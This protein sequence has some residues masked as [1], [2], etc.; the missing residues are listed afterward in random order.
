MEAAETA[1]RHIAMGQFLMLGLVLVFDK[2]GRRG[3]RLAA[4]AAFAL[5]CYLYD[6]GLGST[7]TM[8][9]HVIVVGGLLGTPLIW[10]FI[11]TIFQDE[12]EAKWW[13]WGLAAL[14]PARYILRVALDLPVDGQAAETMLAA[15]RLIQM[16]MLL[17]GLFVALANRNNDLV[18][19]RRNKRLF[20]ALGGGGYILLRVSI[21]LAGLNDWFDRTFPLL[22]AGVALILATIICVGLLRMRSDELFAPARAGAP[23]EPPPGLSP[24]TAGSDTAQWGQRLLK[25]MEAGA[26]RTQGLTV[27]SLAE[28]INLQEYQ[29]RRVINQELGHRNFKAF[30]NTYRIPAAKRRLEDL[31]A[32]NEKILHI[33]LDLGYGSISSFNRTFKSE[34]G[35]TPN[36]W[37]QRRAGAANGD[38]E[39]K[40]Q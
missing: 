30:L 25:E 29:L 39:P 32:T 28:R 34:T 19:S 15:A 36:Q 38:G 13:H 20:I 1:L 21:E 18:E 11:R 10:L 33:A 8:F 12:F 7:R 2:S 22:H 27:A 23:P 5:G 17:D 37:R 14:L 40:T 3:V 24:A 26:Y 6:I 35:L 9:D 4:A 16:G 31:S